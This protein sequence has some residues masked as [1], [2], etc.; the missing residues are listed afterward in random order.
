M[1]DE[2]PFTIAP[3]LS[4]EES[5]TLRDPVMPSPLASTQMPTPQQLICCK[6]SVKTCCISMP[7]E[8]LMKLDRYRQYTIL[9]I[10]CDED[11]PP[12][13]PDRVLLI[14]EEDANVASNKAQVAHEKSRTATRL[15]TI[16]F[17]ANMLASFGHLKVH[18]DKICSLRNRP[19]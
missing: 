8:T 2:D 17:D 3:Q 10:R 13:V 19:V 4:Q 14:A 15:S 11:N 5:I 9:P 7:V 18:I 16:H 12:D 1:N 6:V